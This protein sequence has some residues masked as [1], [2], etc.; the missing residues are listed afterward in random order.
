MNVSSITCAD[1]LSYPAFIEMVGPSYIEN[2]RNT[3]L[4]ISTED[5]YP[6]DYVT[7]DYYKEMLSRP[8]W[9]TAFYPLI[10]I[11]ALTYH[12]D[13]VPSFGKL[14]LESR[15]NGM[16]QRIYYRPNDN[17]VGEDYLIVRPLVR[18]RFFLGKPHHIYIQMV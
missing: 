9:Q 17:Y 3:I 10:A 11:Y 13:K 18:G 1:I 6:G 8:A 15:A 12:F 16:Y 4:I 2:P 5:T 14:C 7:Y